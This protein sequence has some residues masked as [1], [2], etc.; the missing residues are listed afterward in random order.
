MKEQMSQ[1]VMFASTLLKLTRMISHDDYYLAMF[2]AN[3][4]AKSSSK[5]IPLDPSNP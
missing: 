1:V 5:P 3:A 2:K 4:V